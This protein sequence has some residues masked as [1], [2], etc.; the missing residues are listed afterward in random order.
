MHTWQAEL[1]QAWSE[2]RALG[3]RGGRVPPATHVVD[4][5]SLIL[6]TMAAARHDPRLLDG[7]LEWL[8]RN[9]EFVNVQ[10]LGKLAR[11]A[12]AVTLAAL[13]AVA[14]KM[15]DGTGPKWRRLA[16][17]TCL[18]ES[19]PYFL[20]PDGRPRLLPFSNDE[21]FM[22][23]GLIVPP[24]RVHRLAARFPRQG[25][26]TLLLRL[27][28]LCGVT[29][30]CEALWVLASRGDVHPL[31]MAPVIGQSPRH[32]QKILASMVRSGLV[33]IAKAGAERRYALVPGPLD[34]LLRPDGTP[35]HGGSACA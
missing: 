31:E 26:A 20:G 14:A 2:W 18:P 11:G 16:G 29:A 23:H 28:A 24:L 5:E 34:Q 13:G 15:A 19:T 12:D 10:R 25:Q 7:V 30:R 27:R 9:G 6:R 1:D 35:T 22:R 8:R 33:R 3:V 21:T 17:R 4:P 32:T